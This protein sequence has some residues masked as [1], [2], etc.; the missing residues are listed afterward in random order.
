M[1]PLPPPTGKYLVQQKEL[2]F[3]LR[4]E[5]RLYSYLP[6]SYL[7]ENFRPAIIFSHGLFEHPNNYKSLL[8]DLASHGYVVFAP[9][10]ESG[11]VDKK[12]KFP[13]LSL[14][15]LEYYRSV[16]DE[17]LKDIEDIFLSEQLQ[18]AVAIG[19]SFGGSAAL[20]AGKFDAVS[21]VVDLDGPNF[22]S[23]ISLEKPLLILLEEEPDLSEPLAKKLMDS[24][25]DCYDQCTGKKFLEK[26]VGAR[27]NSFSDNGMLLPENAEISNRIKSRI[28]KFLN[29]TL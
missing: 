19:H 2:A 10:H 29:E 11:T 25:S 26:I 20:Q 28:I 17:W 8:S 6:D 27:H 4:K 16:L 22:G 1:P 23:E 9:V 13:D 21:A 24:V 7:V 5:K 3:G 18:K 14:K 12:G 15:T